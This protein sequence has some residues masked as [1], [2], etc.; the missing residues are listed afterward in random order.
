[1]FHLVEASYSPVW[2]WTLTPRSALFA[3]PQSFQF[4]TQLKRVNFHLQVVFGQGWVC[5]L[6][7]I[8]IFSFSSINTE[9]V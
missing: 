5:Y 3:A 8:V 7:T 6:Y 2:V 4:C 1:M 9:L